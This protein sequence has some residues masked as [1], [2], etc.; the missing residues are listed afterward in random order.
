MI[1]LW[2]VCLCDLRVPCRRSEDHR[3]NKERYLDFVLAEGP[4]RE[5]ELGNE[6]YQGLFWESTNYMAVTQMLR[7]KLLWVICILQMIIFGVEDKGCVNL[8]GWEY[9]E[10]RVALKR[11]PCD[12]LCYFLLCSQFYSQHLEQCLGHGR[13]SVNVC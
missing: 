10:R 5:Q 6:V 2:V 1:C 9:H 3:K 8:V 7:N 11:K 13:Y 4:G 12:S